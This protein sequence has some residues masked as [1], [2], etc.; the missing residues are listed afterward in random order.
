MWKVAKC[1]KKDDELTFN[2]H[3]ISLPSTASQK[4]NAFQRIAYSI[5]CDHRLWTP[6]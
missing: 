2:E 1:W 6:S 4:L 5:A 3:V